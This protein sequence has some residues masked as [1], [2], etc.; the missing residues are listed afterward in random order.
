MW[1]TRED[2]LPLVETA[3]ARV[4]NERADLDEASREMVRTNNPTVGYYRAAGN[5]AQYDVKWLISSNR[6]V[7]LYG[8]GNIK[9]KLEDAKILVSKRPSGY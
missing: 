9:G 7:E 3:R 1:F 6:V 5:Y 2:V 8:E 4:L